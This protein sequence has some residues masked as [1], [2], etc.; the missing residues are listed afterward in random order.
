MHVLP[1]IVQWSHLI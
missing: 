1:V